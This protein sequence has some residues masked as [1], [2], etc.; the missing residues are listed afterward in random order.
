MCSVVEAK[1]NAPATISETFHSNRCKLRTLSAVTTLLVGDFISK[2]T[3]ISWPFRH[4]SLLFHSLKREKTEKVLKGEK[5]LHLV[6]FYNNNI[7]K[8][9]K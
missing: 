9:N 7:L 8:A 5:L 1:P 4:F 6:Y 2:V 3:N